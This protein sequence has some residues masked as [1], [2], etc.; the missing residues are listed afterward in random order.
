[1]SRR[2]SFPAWV[3]NPAWTGLTGGWPSNPAL[4][5]LVTGFD[6]NPVECRCEYAFSLA[7]H[8]TGRYGPDSL[9][10]L[11]EAIG[12]GGEPLE[13]LEDVTPEAQATWWRGGVGDADHAGVLRGDS[14]SL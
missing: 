3:E 13:A 10:Q 12:E 5:Q 11:L 6:T 14:G 2:E 8:L 9:R 1:M 7:E 4:D